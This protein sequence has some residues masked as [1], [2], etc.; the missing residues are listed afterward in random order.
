[1][2]GCEEPYMGELSIIRPPAP[3]K[4]AMT[5]VHSSFSLGSLPTL[6]VIELR[7][8][9]CA[10]PVALSIPPKGLQSRTELWWLWPLE[11]GFEGV[12]VHRMLVAGER[13]SIVR[14]GCVRQEPRVA[15]V[16][17]IRRLQCTSTRSS[18]RLWPPHLCRA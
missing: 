3:K 13:Q 1:M 17:A 15:G 8:G 16:G 18:L 4:A 7:T 2:V 12:Q 9:M 5:A 6:N 11:R 14:L 10:I